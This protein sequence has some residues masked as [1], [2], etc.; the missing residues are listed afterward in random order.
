MEERLE[1]IRADPRA[2]DPGRGGGEPG[3]AWDDYR[4]AL[5]EAGKLKESEKL[6]GLLDRTQNADRAF[7]EAAL[8]AHGSVFEHLRQGA[9]RMASPPP[10]ESLLYELRHWEVA[11]QLSILKARA[12]TSEGK[13]EEALRLHL[14]LCQFGRDLG[15]VGDWIPASNSLYCLEMAFAELRDLLEAP[16][17]RPGVIA[18]LESSLVILDQSFPRYEGMQHLKAPWIGSCFLGASRDSGPMA[19]LQAWRFGFSSRMA[20]ATS[21]ERWDQWL[22][23]AGEANR[24]PWPESGRLIAQIR[25]EIQGSPLPPAFTL[26]PSYLEDGSRFRSARAHLRLLRAGAHYRRS[27]EVLDLDD[28]FGGKLLHAVKE[29][30]LRVW[31]VGRDGIDQGGAGNWESALSNDIVLDLPR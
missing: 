25:S 15:E 31:S 19:W 20:A 27:G 23:R 11:A 30:R 14:A 1:S 4:K 10:V 8:A 13:S 17:P 26:S 12:L 2:R 6:I 22:S 18:E 3:N 7:G 28:P 16:S 29:G 21:F 5:S 24:K 9:P